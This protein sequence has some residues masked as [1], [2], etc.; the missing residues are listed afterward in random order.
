MIET[1]INRFGS[2]HCRD[3]ISWPRK[4]RR[5]I[6]RRKRKKPKR[7]EHKLPQPCRLGLFVGFGQKSWN[8][9]SGSPEVEFFY[10]GNVYRVTDSAHESV[11]GIRDSGKP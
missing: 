7:S 1:I 5:S 11:N 9:R 8:E 2:D 4:R 3:E 6:I 10:V